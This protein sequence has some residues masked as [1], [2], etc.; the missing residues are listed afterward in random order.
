M[1]SH[2]DTKPERCLC[3]RLLGTHQPSNSNLATWLRTNARHSFTAEQFPEFV[4]Y[5]GV[6]ACDCT[7]VITVD[8]SSHAWNS[9]YV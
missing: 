2:A 8:C 7:L 6:F 4:N 3:Q 5:G 9:Y 1:K